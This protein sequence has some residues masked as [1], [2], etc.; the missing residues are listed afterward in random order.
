[1]RGWE[2][3]KG[4]KRSYIKVFR[5]DSVLKMINDEAIVYLF[6]FL[7]NWIEKEKFSSVCI[8]NVQEEL[9]F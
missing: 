8:V 4:I 9:R 2:F 5:K 3:V 1:M 6:N 7:I